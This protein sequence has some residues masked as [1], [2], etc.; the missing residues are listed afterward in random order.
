[1]FT[2]WNWIVLYV[3]W[4]WATGQKVMNKAER[5]QCW[6]ARDEFWK[7]M[8]SHN[9]NEDVCLEAKKLF[10]VLCP[11]TWVKHFNRK[12]EYEKFKEQAKQQ[13]FN[14]MDEKFTAKPAKNQT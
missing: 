12:F 3:N 9:E 6:D 4:T 13:G 2:I 10:A 11:P 5:Q 8:K 1:M 7:C 14:K